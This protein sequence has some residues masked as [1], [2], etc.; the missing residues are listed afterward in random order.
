[1]KSY[2][3]SLD[4]TSGDCLMSEECKEHHHING[5]CLIDVPIKGEKYE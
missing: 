5:A 3:R 2:A 1:M 4:M